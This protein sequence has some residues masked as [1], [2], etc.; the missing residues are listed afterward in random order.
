LSSGLQEGIFSGPLW[1]KVL[2]D[3]NF[4]DFYKGVLI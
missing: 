4:G 1:K 2:S 3:H